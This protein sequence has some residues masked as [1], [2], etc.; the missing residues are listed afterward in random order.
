M[1]LDWG[2]MIDNWLAV[3]LNISHKSQ[4]IDWFNVIW[5]QRDE[6]LIKSHPINA[7][8]ALHHQI[9]EPISFDFFADKIFD[10]V[11]VRTILAYISQDT[12]WQKI[13][14]Q[15]VANDVMHKKTATRTIIN[16]IAWLNCLLCKI[17]IYTVWCVYINILMFTSFMD[18]IML[19][20][21][22]LHSENIKRQVLVCHTDRRKRANDSR[23]KI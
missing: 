16:Y 21:W 12:K 10:V 14:M 23:N 13:K 19:K 6:A 17:Y 5:T 22:K 2:N 7:L 8:L 9:F 11:P 18:Y 1:A 15:C 20:K 3:E 4:H